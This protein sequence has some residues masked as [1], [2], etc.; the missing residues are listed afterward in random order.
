MSMAS[1]VT[2]LYV[3]DEEI[4]LFIF[5]RSFRSLYNVIT[6]KSGEEGLK[7]LEEHSGSISVVISDIRMPDMDGLTFIKKASETFSHLAYYILTAFN[8]NSEIDRAIQDKLIVKY[9]TKPFDVD[10]IR[11]EVDRVLSEKH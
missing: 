11:T 7:K 8:Y 2:I 1:P 6:A 9:F 5:D 4:N 3:D 10:L